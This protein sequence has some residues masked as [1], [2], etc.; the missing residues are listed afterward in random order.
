MY[1][2][3]NIW[4]VGHSLGGGLSSLIGATFGAHVV[5]FEAPAA[6]MASKRLHL[7]SPVGTSDLL[8]SPSSL[9]IIQSRLSFTLRKFTTRRIQS[10]W[11]HVQEQYPRVRW[12]V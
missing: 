8:L 1:P 3:A 11:A 7:P 5:A 2:D 12:L 6:K 10:Q 4:I 9:I